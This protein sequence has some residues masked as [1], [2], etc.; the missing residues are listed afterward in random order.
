M[1]AAIRARRLAALEAVAAEKA[2]KAE[3][4]RTKVDW[5][6]FEVEHLVAI[7]DAV[8]RHE[9]GEITADQAA[10]LLE[11]VPGL[12]EEYERDRAGGPTS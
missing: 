9:A 6:S 7:L 4:A 8:E 3:R 11:A 5:S 2:A 1:T 12:V 10:A